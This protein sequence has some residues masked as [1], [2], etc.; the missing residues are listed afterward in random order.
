MA[1]RLEAREKEIRA[2]SQRGEGRQANDLLANGPLGNLE[3]ER[4][5]VRANDRVALVAKLVEVP[6]IYPDVLRE[7]ELPDEAC[8]NDEGGDPALDPIVGRALG[9]GRPIRRPPPDHP[10]PVHIVPGV[11]RIHPPNVRAKRDRIAVR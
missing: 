9:K 2:A 3:L 1:K 5:V 6:I 11:A 7:L 10:S 8:A 4:S